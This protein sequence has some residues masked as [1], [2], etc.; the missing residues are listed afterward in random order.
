[1]KLI[2]NS[3]H[4][5]SLLLVALLT[6]SL[7]GIL[8]KA[9]AQTAEVTVSGTVIDGTIGEP[10]IGVTVQALGTT[11]GTTTDLSGH[12]SIKVPDHVTLRFSFISYKPEEYKVDG[13]AHDLRITLT[14]DTQSLQ[15]LVVIGYGSSRKEDLSTSI[16]TMNIGEDLK[17][18]PANLANML[19]GRM[20]GVTIQNDGGNPL[21]TAELNI[22]G[23][24]SRGGDQV[25][26]VVDGVPG[27]P[28]NVEDVENIT[29]LKDASSAAIYGASVGSGG[30]IVV[31]TKKAGEGALR[32]DLNSSYSFS[33]ITKK[34]HVTTAGEYIKVWTKA[35]ENGDAPSLPAVA[36]VAQYPYGMVDRTDWMDEI[37]RLGAMKHLAAS[38]S[39]GGDRLSAL[40]SVSYDKNDGVLKNTWAESLG[41]RLNAGFTISKWL[42]LSQDLHFTHDNGQGGDINDYGHEGILADA[43]FYPTAATIYEMDEDGEYVLDG[44]GNKV[45]GG[46]VPAYYAHQGISGYGMINNPVASL[47]RLHD[48]RPASTLFSTTSLDIKP[49]YGLDL[50]SRFSL[51]EDWSR[52]EAF[53]PAVKEIGGRGRQNARSITSALHHRW[54]W[55]TTATYARVFGDLHHV[56]AMAGY[57]MQYDN[58]RNN[59]VEGTELPSEDANKIILSNATK[60]PMKP[61]E[62]IVEESMI[63]GF[64]RLAYSYADRYFVTASVRN[65]LSSKLHPTHR[66]AVFPAFSASWKISS[67]DFMKGIEQLNLLKVR[68]SWG[69]VGSVASVDPYAYNVSMAQ[70]RPSVFGADYHLVTGYFQ[71]GISNTDLRWE[72][73]ESWDVGLDL[74]L[75]DRVTLTADYFRKLTRDLIEKVPLVPTMGVEEEPLGNVGSVENKGWELQL[76]YDDHAGDFSWG[77]FANMSLID[78]HVLDLGSRDYIE[79]NL[80]VN[81]MSPIRSKV[82][83]PWQSFYILEADGIF[84]SD[85][86]VAAYTH[87]DPETGV[88]SPIQ[89]NAKAGDLRFVDQNNDG[90]INAEDKTYFGSYM[91]KYTYSFGARFGWKG[92]DLSLDFQGIQGNQIY[93]AYKQMTLT[94]RGTEGNMNAL[95]M[96]S[97][98]FDPSSGVPRIGVAADN[99]G[100]YTSAN[101]CFLEDGSYLRL[102]NV[103]L[104]YTLPKAWME[105][106]S[107]PQGSVRFY[108]N[109]SNI[110]TFTKYSGLDPEVGR[111]G[112]DAG[113][114]PMSRAFTLGLNVSL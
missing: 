8:T 4:S 96:K 60:V 65:D 71:R 19:Q 5:L 53:S 21:A 92:M 110:L 2:L 106:I 62:D 109:G 111:Y 107:L 28:F 108:L 79:D 32:V 9:S 105:A 1:M 103:T 14:E 24:G 113:R 7:T 76:S 81:S 3:I 6:A 10:F 57:T 64:G 48:N 37:F 89:P 36:N 25:L 97:F 91:P 93:N 27:A 13:P 84:K 74:G 16:S 17:S 77:G 33:Q 23:K 41:A 38:I 55:E 56:S 63:S 18:R 45:W 40:L 80:V 69:Q 67:E 39:G 86:E 101:S 49:L 100:N 42:K 68:A 30:V 26:Y 70:A 75:F 99:N 15:E 20:P 59:W 87:K 90:V 29:V 50:V 35:V 102:K 22:R 31:T 43:T 95:V 51:G 47:A 114:Y 82:G 78:S 104:G 11:L 66:S 83:H 73:T 58:W 44:K 72:T 88:V 112:V 94:G 61:T 46:T 12:F 34:P 52:Y 85:K 98:D 54:I